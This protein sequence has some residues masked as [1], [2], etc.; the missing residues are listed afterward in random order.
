MQMNKKLIIFSVITVVLLTACSNNQIVKTNDS[1]KKEEEIKQKAVKAIKTV[2]GAFMNTLNHK[3]KEGG[4]T[5]AANFCSTNAM[6][7]EK[8]VS[9][10]L[11]EGVTV[12]RITDK[13]RNIKN[14]ASLEEQAVLEELKLKIS[15]GEKI[16]MLV[17]Q[18]SE[19]QYQV[20]KPI[21]MLGKCLHCHGINSKRN[22]K[23]YEI[24]SKKYPND[25]AIDYNLGDFRGAFLVEITK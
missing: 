20:Y 17:K 12:R 1:M 21:V 6:D 8:E 5:N 23:V 11:D 4:L 24:I 10:T 19:K 16:D 7:L 2:G 15:N 9:K 18:K 25:K 3:V 14:K 13:P 22:S